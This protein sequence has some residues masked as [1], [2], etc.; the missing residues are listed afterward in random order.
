MIFA[1]V[2]VWRNTAGACVP[3][4]GAKMYDA[5]GI[6]DAGTLLAAI[7]TV[8]SILPFVAFQYG[9]RLRGRS[10]YAKDLARTPGTT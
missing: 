8:L 6:H 3:L 2:N 1:A 9:G 10:R 4:F 5:L 7:G